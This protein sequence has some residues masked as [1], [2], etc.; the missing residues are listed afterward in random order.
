MN[1]EENTKPMMGSDR[2]KRADSQRTLIA[3]RFN[4]GLKAALSEKK[5]LQLVVAL[6]L[7]TYK[8]CKS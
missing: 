2:P 5:H 7:P 6:V 8:I 4:L 1:C 3:K